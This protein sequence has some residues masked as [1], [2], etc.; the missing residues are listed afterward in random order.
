LGRG[1]KQIAREGTWGWEGKGKGG[2]GM[3]T[4]QR[5]E[6]GKERGQGRWASGEREGERVKGNIPQCPA[7][8]PGTVWIKVV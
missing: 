7:Y 4:G 3:D 6:V 2:T 1:K 8:R 5:K